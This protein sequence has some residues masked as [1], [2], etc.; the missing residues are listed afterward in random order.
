M[1]RVCFGFALLLLAGSVEA[2]GFGCPG[3]NA[4]Y[5]SYA[6]EAIT[7]SN[8][9]KSF[10][11]A[12]Y[13]SQAGPGSGAVQAATVTLESNPIRTATDGSTPTA[14][15]GELWTNSTNVKFLVCGQL[16][17]MRFLA[18][19]TGSDAAITVFYWRRQ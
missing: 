4:P 12:T 8:A 9:A 16:N 13:N 15:A 5:V 19:R 14:S 11:A 2:Q 17:V 6:S 3:Q 1:R 18:I 7:V 10:T